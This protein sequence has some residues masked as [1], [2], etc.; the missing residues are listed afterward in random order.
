SS[1]YINP[2]SSFILHTS[3]SFSLNCQAIVIK[4]INRKKAFVRHSSFV[5]MRW[6]TYLEMFPRACPL[7]RA[8]RAFC[9]GTVIELVFDAEEPHMTHTCRNS[10][11]I[12]DYDPR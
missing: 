6:T 3:H 8:T 11:K 7:A 4:A 1:F 5:L 10:K 9:G 12:V 2:P